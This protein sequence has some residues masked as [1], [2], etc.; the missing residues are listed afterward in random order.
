MIDHFNI[1]QEVTKKHAIDLDRIVGRSRQWSVLKARDELC[2]RLR[3][4]THWSYP[5]IGR[6]L[7]KHHSSVI[8]A[9]KRY[10]ER[11]S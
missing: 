9:V 8:A 11:L 5:E 6:F 10:K 1:I 2:F 4:E 3:N 7:N